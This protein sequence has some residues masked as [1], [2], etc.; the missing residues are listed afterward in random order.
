MH[1]HALRNV[2]LK[3]LAPG[4]VCPLLLVSLR[5]VVARL[6]IMAE[7]RAISL[8]DIKSIS[9]SAKKGKA[10]KTS[11]RPFRTISITLALAPP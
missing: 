10:L 1:P 3:D 2:S 9:E 11:P 4:H 7:H 5:V 8:L 6:L